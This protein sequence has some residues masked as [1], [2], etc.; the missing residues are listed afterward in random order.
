[1][2]E[3]TTL[4]N[5]LRILTVTLPHVRSVSLGF[6]VGVGSRYEAEPLAGA[7]HFIEHMLFK[8]TKRHPT[9]LDIAEAIEGK[10]GVFNA[11][12]GLEMTLYWAK[13]AA[14][15]LPEALDV[16]SDML[17]NATFDPEEVEKE[18]AVIGEEIGYSQDTPDSLA[19]ILVSGLQWP[20]HPLGRDVAG[21]RQSLAALNRDSLLA[22]MAD[23][24]RPG[25]TILG[26]AGLVDHREI[27]A[28]AES[29]LGAWEPGP[30]MA[31]EPAPTD[32]LGPKL[33]VEKKETE[34][35]HLSFS[36]TALPRSDPD[37]FA[38][39]LLNVILGEGMR[40]RLFQLVRER[41][42]L[43]YNVE[44]YVSA[45]QDTGAAGVDASVGPDRVEETIGTILK[46]L[47]RLRQEQVPEIELRKA[48]DFVKGRLA[49]TME[50]SFTVAAWYARQQLLGPEMMNQ[51]EVVKRYEAVQATDIQRLAQTIF[52]KERLNLAIV[53]PFSRNGDRFRRAI[54]F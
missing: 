28:W 13:V 24:Y 42:G 40:S 34:Q 31:W 53:G 18:R 54:D 22:Y 26:L 37:R 14:V 44:S 50:D 6:F 8:G 12:T 33:H 4:N 35:A 1:M 19:Y 11:S 17:L 46:E 7:S 36:F 39:R 20:N 25:Q 51:E 41:L 10:G 16:L 27:V 3:L 45:L 2:H 15:H 49:L 30:T 5:G 52:Q 9:A 23:H 21:T 43:A 48:L 47:D 38:L 29:N 32:C